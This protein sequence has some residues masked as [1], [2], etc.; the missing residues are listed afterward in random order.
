MEWRE[1]YGHGRVSAV[2][3]VRARYGDIGCDIKISEDLGGLCVVGGG[4]ERTDTHADVGWKNW[5]EGVGGRWVGALSDM[6]GVGG[7][8]VVV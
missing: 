6:V 1:D 5:Y 7:Y 4:F 8:L 3:E 2:I